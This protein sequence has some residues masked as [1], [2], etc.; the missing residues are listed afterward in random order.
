[1][2]LLATTLLTVLAVLCSFFYILFYISSRKHGKEKGKALPGPRPLPIIGNL[3]MLGM[4]PHQSLY[5]LAK[6]H[7][8]MMSIWLGS[9]PTVV[10][11][12]PQVAEMFLKTHD[13]IFASRP[14]VQVLQ[15]I[16]NSQR[17]IAFTEYGPY[18]RS[19]RKICNMQLFT[20]SKIESFAP[21]RKE[22]LMHFTES[23]KEAAKA[24]EV[25]NISKKLAEIN[26]E[27]TLKMV[28]GPV[29]KY[30]E[31]NLNELI[32]ELTK[33]A[34]VFNLADFVP[35][36]GAF[37]L[38]GIKASTQTLGEK[39]DKALETIIK[40][41]LQKKQ[42][43]FV[44]TLLTEL[45][46]T[47]NPNGDIMDWNSIKAITL[48]MIVGGFDT[49]AATLEWAL[50]ELIRHPRVMLKLQQELKSIFG[51]KRIVEEND[52][53][54]LEYLDMVVRE[55]L[56]LHPIAPLLIP[57]ESME[58]IVIDGYYIPK[59]SRVLVNIWAIGR[60]PNIWSNNVEEF[61]PER[62][63]DSNIDLHGHNFALIPFGAGRRL[64]P[65]KKL[66]LITVKLILAQL[67]HCFD[68]ELPGGMSSNELNMTENFGVS[69]PRKTS[70]CVKP[71][72]RMY[73]Y[74]V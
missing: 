58:D 14:K 56:R 49:S 72:Y 28:L 46:Q 66:G 11:S 67:V 62:F 23:L 5:H 29:K 36:L 32:E 26:G 25:V 27:M 4:L 55:T 52:L 71:I 17:G 9:V 1:M 2:A 39:L 21:T 38:Q 43:D 40:D 3:H 70:L 7:G 60:D 15:S 47:I 69:L 16:S 59:K 68:W 74:N 50:S 8:P 63:I 41:H 13:A 73:E 53:P 18:W 54:K 48:D 6:K 44:G 42:D 12:S 51:N 61:S 30:K 65:G 37:D 57:R 45:N 24:K 19:V 64:C 34:G 33:I 22:V 20:T 31:F 35:F 10:V